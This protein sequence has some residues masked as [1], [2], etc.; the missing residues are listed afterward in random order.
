MSEF[1]SDYSG[2]DISLSDD[3]SIVAIGAYLNNGKREIGNS[4]RFEDLPD[5]G[6][7]RVLKMIMASGY[8]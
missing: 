3:G 2:N 5:S 6:H 7:V 4:G 1:A 8:K